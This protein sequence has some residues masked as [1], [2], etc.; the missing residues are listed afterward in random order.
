MTLS[1]RNRPFSLLGYRF[2]RGL[3]DERPTDREG[4]LYL[5]ILP[6]QPT[7]TTHSTKDRRVVEISMTLTIVRSDK[8]DPEELQ[9]EDAA[10]G[11]GAV[12]SVKYEA[13]YIAKLNKHDGDLQVFEEMV[14]HAF[15]QLYQVVRAKAM[16][17]AVDSGFDASHIPIEVDAVNIFKGQSQASDSISPPLSSKRSRHKPPKAE[18]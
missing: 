2:V 3:F 9:V 8:D 6:V 10:F 5:V 18:S 1:I 7:F 16:S 11:P 13:G 12:L 14:Q 17:I 15:E 4:Q